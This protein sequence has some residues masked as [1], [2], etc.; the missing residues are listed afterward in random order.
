MTKPLPGALIAIL[1]VVLGYCCALD[2][3]ETH[4][5]ETTADDIYKCA[6]Y[7]GMHIDTLHWIKQNFSEYKDCQAGGSFALSRR[8]FEFKIEVEV[9]DSWIVEVR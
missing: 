4:R 1:I 7:T 5:A 3:D 6:T 2:I 9:K 8:L